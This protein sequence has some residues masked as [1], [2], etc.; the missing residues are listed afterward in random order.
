M[1]ITKSPKIVLKKRSTGVRPKKAAAKTDADILAQILE[2]VRPAL[3]SH[4][5]NI[6]LVSFKEGAVSLKFMGACGSC[7]YANGTLMQIMRLIKE[8]VKSAKQIRL[9]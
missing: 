2:G 4:G 7:H 9:V 3:A 5:G 1:N 8:K 6:E